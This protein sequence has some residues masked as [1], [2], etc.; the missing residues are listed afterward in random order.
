MKKIILASHGG[1]AEGMKAT[2]KM[3]SGMDDGI[4]AFGFHDGEDVKEVFRQVSNMINDEDEFVIITD[5]PGGSVNT[6]LT[7]LV[8]YKNVHLISGMNTILVLSLALSAECDDSSIL[9]N[10]EEGKNSIVYINDMMKE[11]KKEESGDFFD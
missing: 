1:L 8:E 4:Y 9:Q 2:V 6:V 5:A 7:P 11:T 10:I 3:L